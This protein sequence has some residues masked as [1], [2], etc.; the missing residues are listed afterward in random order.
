M[1]TLNNFRKRTVTKKERVY[2]VKEGGTRTEQE[3]LKEYSS[4][5]ETSQAMIS[6]EGYCELRKSMK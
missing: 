3:L 6:F 2:P 1:E 4:M 5:E